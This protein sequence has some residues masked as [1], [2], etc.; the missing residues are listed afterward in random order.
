MAR[1]RCARAD[2]ASR[3]GRSGRARLRTPR[4]GCPTPPRRR[5]TA[6]DALSPRGQGRGSSATARLER[7]SWRRN[8]VAAP[9]RV[10]QPSVAERPAISSHGMSR[11]GGPAARRK[12]AVHQAGQMDD[13]EFEALCPVDGEHRHGIEI[14]RTGVGWLVVCLDERVQVRNQERDPI[15]SEQ[16]EHAIERSRRNE[17]RS[18]RRSDRPTRPAGSGG[19]CGARSR[20]EPLWTCVPDQ[21]R[22]RRARPKSAWRHR[23]RTP[24]GKVRLRLSFRHGL[25]EALV[26]TPRPAEQVRQVLATE[27]VWKA[28]RERVEL[29]RVVRDRRPRADR[30][31]ADAPP[32]GQRSPSAAGFALV[33]LACASAR[34]SGSI[35]ALLRARTPMSRGLAPTVKAAGDG[36]GDSLG[37]VVRGG[38]PAGAEGLRAAAPAVGN[39]RLPATPPLRPSGS[40]AAARRRRWPGASGSC[41]S[42]SRA[43]GRDG[44]RRTSRMLFAAAPRKL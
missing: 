38:I 36:S 11:V 1:P 41:A 35:S 32:P 28:G 34:A 25:P 10:D 22:C 17:R 29:E 14:E 40:P 30:R 24:A 9:R 7:A 39:L 8:R 23:P 16:S 37:L 44:A 18:E 5:A 4:P 2:R 3:S 12:A 33:R 43:A 42:R 15:L 26:A 31:A 13:P 20:R 27:L 6:G 19:R 21:G